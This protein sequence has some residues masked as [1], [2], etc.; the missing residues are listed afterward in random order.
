MSRH[1]PH[2]QS[3]LSIIAHLCVMGGNQSPAERSKALKEILDEIKEH[4]TNFPD[5]K[6]G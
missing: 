3:M 2:I 5:Y 4:N 6:I 1:E